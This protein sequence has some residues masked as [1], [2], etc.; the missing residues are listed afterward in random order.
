[1][2]KDKK[3]M[4]I[5]GAIALVII[6]FVVALC[7][8]LKKPTDNTNKQPDNNV[9]Q[10]DNSTETTDIT[11]NDDG[12]IDEQEKIVL[13]LR[14]DRDIAMMQM[15]YGKEEAP[16]YLE[17]VEEIRNYEILSAE[18][19]E[20][21]IYATVLVSAPDMYTITKNLQIE[22]EVTEEKINEAL[23]E[24]LKNAEPVETEVEIAFQKVGEVWEA[25]FTEEF[26]DAYT[27]GLL[28]LQK[29]YYDEVLG[30][31]TNEE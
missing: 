13:D 24:A 12:V 6:G 11:I 21:V 17:K 16:D 2:L 30:G 26:I 28:R 7:L 15:A 10:G 1:M 19:E 9:S 22:G 5:I 4:I 18:Q 25:T 23:I 20:N 8:I 31:D 14:L 29:E 27:G 3:K